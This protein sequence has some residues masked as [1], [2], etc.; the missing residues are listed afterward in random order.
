MLTEAKA[1]ATADDVKALNKLIVEREN[2]VSWLR[3]IRAAKRI[4]CELDE[5]DDKGW[6]RGHEAQTHCRGK[7]VPDVID[8]KHALT[9]E[10][11]KRCHELR[12]KI[13]AYGIQ[14]AA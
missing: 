13:A 2:L 5:P 10:I 6:P 1:I 8:V 11:E 12:E 3:A 9:I 7:F 14:V 4:R